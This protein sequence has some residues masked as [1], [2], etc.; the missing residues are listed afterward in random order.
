[1]VIPIHS[2]LFRDSVAS[3][4]EQLKALRATGRRAYHL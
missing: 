2:R 3:A 4:S 1:M